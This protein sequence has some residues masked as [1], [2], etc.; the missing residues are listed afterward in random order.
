MLD[1][2]EE[3]GRNQQKRQNERHFHEN[4]TFETLDSS[5]QEHELK[6]AFPKVEQIFFAGY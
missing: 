1:R 2:V 3:A 5:K 4:W 6:S